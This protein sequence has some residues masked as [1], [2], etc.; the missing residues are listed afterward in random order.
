MFSARMLACI[1]A[2]VWVVGTPP[3]AS[4]KATAA[5]E[6]AVLAS[7]Q[8]VLDGLAKRDKAAILQ[9][10]LPGGNATLMRDGKPVQLSFE[11]LADRLS[12][13]GTT[14][15]EERIHDALVRIDDNVAIVWAPFEFLI[16]GKVDHCGRDMAQLVRVDGRWLIAALG[17]NSRTD[18]AG[19][20]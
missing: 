17:D 7:F 3:A 18:C 6:K 2:L 9:R 13:P 5:D 12:Q 10:L 8:A 15:R 19:K 16:D 4:A 20:K 14:T 11:A 1:V